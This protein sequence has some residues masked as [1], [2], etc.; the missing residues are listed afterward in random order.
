LESDLIPHS[1]SHGLPAQAALVL[2]P[3]PDDEVFGCG[4]AIAAHVRAGV[5]VHVVILT[6]GALFGDAS[7]RANESLAA[8]RLLGSGV[9]D[10]WGLADS[11]MCYSE[12]LVQRLVDK[13][14]ST[15]ADLIYAP[16]PLELHPDHR[17]TT[18]LAV[19]AARRV[20]QPVR[21]AFYE[22]GAPLRPN[23]LLDITDL[24]ELKDAAM[25]CFESQL[26]QQDYLNQIRALNKY[27]S[28]TLPREVL[29]AEA[30]WVLSARDLDQTAFTGLSMFASPGICADPNTSRK[31]MPLVSILIRSMDRDCLAEAMDSVA[32]QTYPH[33]EV[34]VAAARPG[35]RPL[36]AKCGPFPLRLVQTDAPLLRSR[37]ANQAMAQAKGDLLL[38]L[39]DDDWLMP[40]H[41]ARL[42]HAL[43]GQPHAL[44][45]YTGISLVDAKGRPM[46]QTFELPFDAIRQM[47]G[48][49]TPIHAVLFRSEVLAQGCRFDEA[50][51]RYE[52]WDFWLQLAR[53]A[54]MV[55]LPGV[56]AVY[57]I[58]DSSGVHIDAGPTGAAAA[59]VYQ[60]WASEWTPQ[61]IGQM[62]LRVWTHPQLEARLEDTRLQLTGT[63][64]R[65]KLAENAAIQDKQV[66]SQQ[67]QEIR[68][69]S[70]RI[71]DLSVS[72]AKLEY[73]L[74]ALFDSHSW[75]ITRPLRWVAQLM[76]NRARAR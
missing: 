3:H 22:V 61:Q 48:N 5:P 66:M 1:A 45:A 31:S 68:V 67:N 50:L 76:R 30:F 19:E 13:I 49:L 33:I 10:L 23:V 11:N 53:L 55:H 9:P 16:S 25:R 52:D 46:G 69:L 41:I 58:H 29:A 15:G 7:T 37:A 12:E 32:L 28:Y 65:L 17:Q 26:S 35:H 51:D 64:Q 20:A 47:A 6:D 36:P 57:R 75:R 40:G 59:V 56:S 39:D 54:P 27:R 62:M 34:V 71:D 2:A 24:L 14:V 73:D 44:A 72:L 21:L 74:A 60:K 4:G 8:A 43:A 18:M 38:F 63:E 70:E 42:A